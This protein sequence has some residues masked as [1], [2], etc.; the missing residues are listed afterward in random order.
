[1]NRQLVTK[2]SA[3]GR[4]IPQTTMLI[5]GDATHALRPEVSEGVC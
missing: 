5:A 1:M 2:T 4:A 3:V